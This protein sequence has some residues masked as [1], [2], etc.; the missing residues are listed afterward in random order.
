MTQLTID[1]IIYEVLSSQAYD[2][3]ATTTQVF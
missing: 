3:D 2:N 1:G